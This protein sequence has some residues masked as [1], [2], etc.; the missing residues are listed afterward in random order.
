MNRWS[1]VPKQWGSM[2]AET[3]DSVLLETSRFEPGNRQSLL[4]LHPVRVVSAFQ[5]DEIPALFRQLE[6][7][8]AAGF[9]VAGFVGYECGYHFQSLEGVALIPSELPLA[10]FGVYREPLV[11][12]HQMSCQE[13]EPA[14]PPAPQP[15]IDESGNLMEMLP[16]RTFLTISENEYCT[17]IERIQEYIGAGDTYQVNFTDAVEARTASSAA[18]VFAA[19]SHRQPVSYSAFLN[20][21][22]NHILS[23]SPEL[24]F[25]I[26]DG[27]IVTRPMKGTMP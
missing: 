12:N 23:F 11:H 3:A 18:E 6:E 27:R 22:G 26:D 13:G 16:E 8:L 7:A 15:P 24:F 21:D 9:Y 2:V 5:L 19:L 10:W 20:V 25:R 4:F 17:K 14:Q 1:G